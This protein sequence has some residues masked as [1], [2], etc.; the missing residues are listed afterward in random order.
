[1]MPANDQAR[2]LVIQALENERE[3]LKI[4]RSMPLADR[5]DDDESLDSLIEAYDNLHAGFLDNQLLIMNMRPQ[6]MARVNPLLEPSKPCENHGQ[7]APLI[8]VYQKDGRTPLAQMETTPPLRLCKDHATSDLSHYLPKEKWPE[9][10]AAC[11]QQTG[12]LV[13]YDDARIMFMD[14]E[15]GQLIPPPSVSIA[16]G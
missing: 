1:M 16:R 14:S 5:S 7:Y 8:V 13:S 6:C 3:Q 2:K 10:Q 12:Q 11:T 4:E 15:T 9:I